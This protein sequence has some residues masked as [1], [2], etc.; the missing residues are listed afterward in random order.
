VLFDRLADMLAPG[1]WLYIGHSENLLG[2]SDR[3]QLM[4]RTIYR[5]IR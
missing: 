1:G 5:R 3:F 2:I 4:G